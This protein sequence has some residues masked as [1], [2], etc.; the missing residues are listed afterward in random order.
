MCPRFSGDLLE[1]IGSTKESIERVLLEV[2]RNYAF[3]DELDGH[4]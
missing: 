2:G 3:L 1:D 4:G